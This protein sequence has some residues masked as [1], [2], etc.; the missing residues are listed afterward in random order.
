MQW[1]FIT[2]YKQSKTAK[3]LLMKARGLGEEEAYA[4]LRKAAMD[5][6]RRVAEVAEAIVTTAG[7]LG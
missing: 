4:L 2:C 1:P 6:G 3:G 7:L 5:Q